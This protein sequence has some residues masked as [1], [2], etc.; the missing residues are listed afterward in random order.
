MLQN[1][2]VNFHVINIMESWFSNQ[3]IRV[4]WNDS[5]SE[6]VT[7]ASGVRQGGVLSPILFA[8]YVDCVL[9]NL[10]LSEIGYFIGKQCL[11]SFMYADDLILL[12]FSVSDLQKLVNLC[13][14]L[15]TKL[16]LPT[17]VAKSHCMGIGPRFRAECSSITVNGQTLNWVNKTKILGITIVSDNHFKC[18]WHD[19][20]SNF[21]KASNSIFSNLG[22]N[23]PINV[24]LKLIS[25]KCVPILMYW[26]S[27]LS[28]FLP[29]SLPDHHLLI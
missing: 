4:K 1:K 12:S 2:Y 16:D 8:A 14:I 22:P 26:M 15:F 17:K 23:P 7:L 9:D 18:D 27:T 20:R 5:L 25:S 13:H 29:R 10:E 6:Q 21:Y 3:S 28:L 11:N 19:S 24:T